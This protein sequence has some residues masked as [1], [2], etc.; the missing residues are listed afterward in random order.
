MI[1]RKVIPIAE[2]RARRIGAILLPTP[3]P[4]A[5]VPLRTGQF[6]PPKPGDAEFVAR[7]ALHNYA[8]EMLGWPEPA[9]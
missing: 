7:L 6:G 8:N 3:A 4:M 5:F 9:A 2:A 1:E